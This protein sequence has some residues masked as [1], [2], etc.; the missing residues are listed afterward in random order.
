[1]YKIK[2]RGFVLCTGESRRIL[3]TRTVVADHMENLK[4]DYDWGNF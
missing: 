2:Y 4:H 3:L 1:M